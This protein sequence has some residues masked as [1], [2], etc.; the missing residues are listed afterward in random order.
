MSL[1]LSIPDQDSAEF[2]GLPLDV[3]ME[4]KAWLRELA[5]VARATHKGQACERA[6]QVLHTSWKTV[7]RKYDAWRHS[8]DW[9]ALINRALT[10]RRVDQKRPR[11]LELAHSLIDEFAA[12]GR[13]D[14]I[15]AF[16]VPYPLNVIADV[17][18]A[19]G[20][21]TSSK[22][23]VSLT[24]AQKAAVKALLLAFGG[25]AKAAKAALQ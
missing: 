21:A 15:A 23:I 8:G 14:L 3:K 24:R 25:D 2:A 17:I 5:T 12:K 10:Q 22:T 13:A 20:P 7:R 9:R 4:V 11:M 16:G 6:A 1:T 19:T 18:G